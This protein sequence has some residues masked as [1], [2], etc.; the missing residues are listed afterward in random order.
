MAQ[1]CSSSEFASHGCFDRCC[2]ELEGKLHERL[3]L[4][5][6]LVVRIGFQFIAVCSGYGLYFW[7]KSVFRF[8]LRSD[9]RRFGG[10]QSGASEFSLGW[11]RGGFRRPTRERRA[12]G[13]RAR[14]SEGIMAGKAR[15]A[16]FRHPDAAGQRRAPKPCSPSNAASKTGAGPTSSIG[17]MATPQ[18]LNQ[19]N[20]GCTHPQTHALTD[21]S[22]LQKK[23][24]IG[25][26]PFRIERSRKLRSCR[27]ET[28]SKACW[29]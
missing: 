7:V 21:D 19:K 16:E 6:S 8:H 22:A 1:D 10:L 2:N 15:D 26:K 13:I 17:G 29:D 20:M 25:W 27:A 18:S 9:C 11:S 12:P 3:E 28:R 24:L 14:A 23:S 4:A 5:N